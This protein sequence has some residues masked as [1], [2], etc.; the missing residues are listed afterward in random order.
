MVESEN[1]AIVPS[2]EP[3]VVVGVVESRAVGKSVLGRELITSLPGANG[4]VEELVAII[5][6]VQPSDSSSSS[7]LGGEILPPLLSISGGRPYENY[8]MIDGLGNNSLLDPDSDI[9]AGDPKDVPGHP[10]ALFINANLVKEVKVFDNNIPAKYGG[11]TGG[12][13]A[14]ETLD[15]S[16]EFSGSA[17]YRMTRDNWTSFHVAP[18]NQAA[19]DGSFTEAMQPRFEKYDA[20]FDLSLPVFEKSGLLASYQVVYSKIPLNNF[21]QID[22]QFRKSENFL[23]KYVTQLSSDQKLTIQAL[24]NPY[25]GEYFLDRTK[26]SAFTLNGGG[27]N[28][29]V[30]Y[31][32]QTN[33]G[34][35]VVT[36]GLSF[37][38]NSRTAPQYHRNW[39]ATD[40]K[41]WG[42]PVGLPDYSRE[43]G[44]GDINK[45][46]KSMQTSLD[47]LSEL[48]KAAGATHQVNTGLLIDFSQ[49]NFERPETAYAYKRPDGAVS[50]GSDTFACDETSG[51]EQFFQERIV[52]QKIDVDANIVQLA[53]Y[54]DDKIDF[55]KLEIR[56]G[57]RTSYDDFT[58]NTDVAPRLSAIYD[59]F[60][61]GQTEFIAGWNRYYAQ[62]LLTYQLREAIVPLVHVRTAPVDNDSEWTVKQSIAPSTYEYSNL[63][64]PYN[65][66]VVLGLNQAVLGGR[67]DL[68]YVQR[69]GYDEFAR[70]K[71]P[72]DSS[73]IYAPLPW[74]LNNNGESH[75]K[76]Y[77]LA[78]ER[79]WVDQYFA[80]NATYSESTTTNL[81]YEDRLELTDFE[82]DDRVWFDGKLLWL[83]ELP[84]EDF[85]RPWV[86]N[87]IYTVDLSHGVMFSNV[88]NYRSGYRAL[89]DS[90]AEPIDGHDVYVE[91]KRP[92]SFIFN[93]QVD[94]SPPAVPEKAL[95]VTL[96]ILNVF[97]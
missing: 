64:T 23:L 56:P 47:W 49:A 73:D 51:S 13:V 89:V 8:F 27:G 91:G 57:L 52:Y 38:E 69:D 37:S 6:G 46:Q 14:V 53:F 85:N 18:E 54:L 21:G 92:S 63:K 95:T 2:L 10:E 19:F 36:T 24:Y 34:V 25:S 84:R 43:G 45:T 35:L 16:A 40:S 68:R 30:E 15:P 79:Q 94:W 1:P 31:E 5:P 96:E 3:I 71:E 17:R 65:D 41:D 44:Y 72:Y 93:W 77:R 59:L 4:N 29:S 81:S 50:C 42:P 97:N 83:D 70:E 86:A 80:L 39:E 12:V 58:E 20:G 26:D 9:S 87:L 76:S 82:P 74:R 7:F 62:P 90:G 11:F 32:N 78:W 33:H 75:Y 48:F 28:V 88:T 60:N 66:E 67:L 55:G 22:N 61:N